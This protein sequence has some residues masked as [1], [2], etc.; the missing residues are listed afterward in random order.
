M[1]SRRI[2]GIIAGIALLALTGYVCYQLG[3]QSTQ[4]LADSNL[5]KQSASHYILDMTS[6]NSSRAYKVG[7]EFYQ[8]KN[9]EAD[10]KSLSDTL[11]AD[12]TVKLSNEE[13]YFGRDDDSGK[14][15]YTATVE[16]LPISP[17][18]GKTTANVVIRLVYEGGYWKIDSFQ[19]T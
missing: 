11:Q 10:I 9:T 17:R 6:G 4:K 1:N 7:S 12:D 15:I 2:I 3:I 5:A 18:T 14:A 16:N 19:L 8:A 13:A